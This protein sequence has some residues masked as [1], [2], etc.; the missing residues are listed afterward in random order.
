[1]GQFELRPVALAETRTLR[2]EV[3]RPHQ[4]VED[5]AGH[6]PPGS[7]AFGAFQGSELVAVGLVGPDGEPGHWRVRGMAAAPQVR[8][9]GAGSA[10]LHALVQHA[11]A[12]GARR[13]WCNART[14]ALT[15]YQRAG[16]VVASDEFEPPG[17]GPHYRMELPV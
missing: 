13:V 12:H 1:M 2:Q 15:L 16:F 4:T 8:G 7:V 17:I 3:L 10:V 9:R 14:P 6:E 11:I 5:L